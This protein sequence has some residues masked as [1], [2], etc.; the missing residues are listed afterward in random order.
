MTERSPRTNSDVQSLA[1]NV[2]YEPLLLSSPPTVSECRCRGVQDVRIQLTVLDEPIGVKGEWVIVDVG[3]MQDV[4]GGTK[5][6]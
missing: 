2:I 4:P 6:G 1:N 5:D 3:V